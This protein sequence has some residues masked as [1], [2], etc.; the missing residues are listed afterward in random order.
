MAA[1]CVVLVAVGLPAGGELYTA[2]RLV[3]TS[4]TAWGWTGSHPDNGY[5]GSIGSTLAPADADGGIPGPAPRVAVE[6]EAKFPGRIHA[7]WWW[8]VR[9]WWLRELPWWL[10]HPRTKMAGGR[11]TRQ[12]TGT[13]PASPPRR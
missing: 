13:R 3:P 6:D 1:L 7:P 5:W 4:P 9:P 11:N 12:P 10:S 2:T 8:E